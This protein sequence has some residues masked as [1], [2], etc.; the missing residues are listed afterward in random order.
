MEI[1]KSS[2]KSKSNEIDKKLDENNSEKENMF[3]SLN[4]QGLIKIF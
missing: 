3:S 2:K 4:F 1:T